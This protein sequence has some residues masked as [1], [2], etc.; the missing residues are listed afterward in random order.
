MKR[1]AGQERPQPDP[2]PARA[3]SSGEK[4][5][6]AMGPRTV[7]QNALS[8]VT[9]VRCRWPS[10]EGKDRHE[11]PAA[12]GRGCSSLTRAGLPQNRPIDDSEV[13]TWPRSRVRAS[14]KRA[15]IRDSHLPRVRVLTDWRAGCGKSARP[16]LREGWRNSMRHPYLYP[17]APSYTVAN[18]CGGSA[19]PSSPCAE[20]RAYTPPSASSSSWRPRST[21][22]PWSITR[23]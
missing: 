18:T 22:R 5:A 16:V 20:S 3:S 7:G 11:G 21:I 13:P 4:A 15:F 2:L 1:A 8:V 6:V 19:C 17:N 12:R 14:H 10:Q 23:I 9:G